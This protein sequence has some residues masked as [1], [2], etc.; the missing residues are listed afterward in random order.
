[1]K[2]TK[3]MTI[4]SLLISS[5]FAADV[6]LKASTLKWEGT[7][8]T[9]KHFGKIF[10]KGAKAEVTDGKLKS[11]EFVV[12]MNSFTVDDLS[13]EWAKKFIDHMKSKDFFVTSKYPT[14]KLVIKEVKDGVAKGDLTIK[15]KT[16]PVSFKVKSE[17]NTHTGVLKFDRTKFGMT[18]GSGD[19]FK[20]LGDKMIHN[21][22]TVDFKLVTK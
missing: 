19:F 22:V 17:K 13:G 15:G 18:Y 12:D 14:S 4:A 8:V 7:K 11:G 10:F 5:A 16:N 6:D 21:D 1:M 20:G 9:G 3:L 2:M